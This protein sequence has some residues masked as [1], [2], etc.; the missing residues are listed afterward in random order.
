VSDEEV[1]SYLVCIQSVCQIVHRIVPVIVHMIT[2]ISD[3]VLAGHL[4]CQIIG[5]ALLYFFYTGTS[6]HGGCP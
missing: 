5:L 2:Y 6:L 4:I 1:D 3:N